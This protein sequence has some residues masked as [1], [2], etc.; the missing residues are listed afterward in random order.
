MRPLTKYKI[1]SV[2]LP[3]LLSLNDVKNAKG[4]TEKFATVKIDIVLIDSESEENAYDFR[5]R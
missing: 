2:V 5:A 3:E 4:N 1:G